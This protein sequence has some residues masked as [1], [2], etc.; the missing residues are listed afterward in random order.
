M[1]SHSK[2]AET[3]TISHLRC[4]NCG[5]KQYEY[6]IGRDDK[7][8]IPKGQPLGATPCPDCGCATLRKGL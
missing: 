6:G 8:P 7:L 1:P 4:G 2:S 3:Y 5:W